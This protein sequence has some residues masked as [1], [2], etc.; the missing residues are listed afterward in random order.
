[1][2]NQ[3]I[4][5]FHLIMCSSLL[6]HFMIML[7]GKFCDEPA[8]IGSDF[9]VTE[10]GVFPNW[11]TGINGAILLFILLDERL[12]KLV[13]DIVIRVQ[14]KTSRAVQDRINLQKKRL[15]CELVIKMKMCKM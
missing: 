6:R 14:H 4:I 7:D 8:L 9:G 15:N 1:M 2:E 11:K 3:N 13:Y 12:L 10:L 5:T